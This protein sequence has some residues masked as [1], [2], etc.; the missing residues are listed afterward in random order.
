[1]I[2]LTI[3][4]CGSRLKRPFS[5]PI[6]L[7]CCY[8]L[9]FPY[10]NETGPAFTYRGRIDRL[11]IETGDLV[12]RK[13]L[14]EPDTVLEQRVSELEQKIQAIENIPAVALALKL[15]GS[16]EQNTTTTPTPSPQTG[17]PLELVSCEY[18]FKAGQYS[19][20]NRHLRA[21]GAD[22]SGSAKLQ[23]ENPD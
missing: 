10:E 22:N 21:R 12:R 19:Y 20:E 13:S 1:M 4:S 11:P 15:R 6:A 16:A 5:A 23:S 17:S 9:R 2:R 8:T 3:A 14:L 7:E 18:K